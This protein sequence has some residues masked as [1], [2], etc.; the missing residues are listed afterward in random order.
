MYAPN[1]KNGKRKDK[2][3]DFI[4]KCW[5]KMRISESMLHPVEAKNVGM[6]AHVVGYVNNL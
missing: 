1:V 6:T 5:A 2:I 4:L 3:P